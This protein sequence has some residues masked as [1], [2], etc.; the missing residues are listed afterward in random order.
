M[1][2]D[3]FPPVGNEEVA[4]IL[5]DAGRHYANC[6]SAE[7]RRRAEEDQR[8]CAEDW[9]ENLDDYSSLYAIIKDPDFQHKL[10]KIR[11]WR[12]YDY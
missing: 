4:K 2:E 12:S 7:S 11:S 1:D 9:V 6:I 10:E 5:G 8:R 3:K